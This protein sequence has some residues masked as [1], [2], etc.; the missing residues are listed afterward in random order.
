M[1]LLWW[2][3]DGLCVFAKRLERGSFVWP[4]T[5]SGV[6]HLSRAQLSMLLEGI[7]WV[8][9]ETDARQRVKVP[10]DE[11]VA[12]HIDP[13]S[14][15]SIREGAAEALTGAHIG[16]AIERRKTSQPEC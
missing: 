15:G 13:E 14:C 11:E 10:H 2:D 9:R 6:V 8:R 5:E 4:H 1:K 3:G 16:Q 7:D 12:I